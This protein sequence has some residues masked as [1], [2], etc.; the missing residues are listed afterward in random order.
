MFIFQHK[1]MLTL[2]KVMDFYYVIS[3]SNGDISKGRSLGL[4]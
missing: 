1:T 3:G 4:R 2:E